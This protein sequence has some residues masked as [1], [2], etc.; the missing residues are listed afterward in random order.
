MVYFGIF[1][2]PEPET[3]GLEDKFPIEKPIS[4]TLLAGHWAVPFWLGSFF[5]VTWIDHPN[6]G[7]VTTDLKRSRF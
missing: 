6:G 3:P 5:Q 1:T 7:R 2:P 4:D